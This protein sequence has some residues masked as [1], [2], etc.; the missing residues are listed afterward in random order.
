MIPIVN[1]SVWLVAKIFVIIVLVLYCIF[2]LVVVK[3]VQLMTDTID[4][5][6][7]FSIKLLSFAHLAFAAIVL[8][9]ALTIL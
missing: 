4:T 1:I 9:V 2:A 3:Q 5:G 6:S 7:E 8:I